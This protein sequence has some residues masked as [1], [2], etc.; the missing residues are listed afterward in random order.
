MINLISYGIV[1]SNASISEKYQMPLKFK[2][3]Y[4]VEMEGFLGIQNMAD[5]IEPT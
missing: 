5:N 4:F 2:M 1:C 3:Q